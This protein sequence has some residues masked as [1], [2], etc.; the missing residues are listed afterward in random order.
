MYFGCG[1][2]ISDSFFIHIKVS[3]KPGQIQFVGVGA[4]FGINIGTLHGATNSNLEQ[5]D[6]INE[7]EDVRAKVNESSL[8]RSD[9][10]HQR[11]CDAK[12][13]NYADPDE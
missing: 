4:R 6:G 5:L 2:L 3:V 11:G 9:P 8:D 1:L 12:D 7:D 10:A 13:M